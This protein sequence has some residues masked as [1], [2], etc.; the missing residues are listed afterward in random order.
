MSAASRLRCG[1]VVWGIGAAGA[2]CGPVAPG[3][4]ADARA[5]AAVLADETVADP[6]ACAA[7]VDPDLRGDCGVVVAERRMAAGVAPGAV[8]GPLAPG[9]WADEC[10]FRAAEAAM[11]VGDPDAA[12]DL[13]L[14]VRSFRDACAQHLWDPELAGVWVGPDADAALGRGRALH[15]TWA[16]RLGGRTDLDDRFWR[17]WYRLGFAHGVPLPADTA[18]FCAAAP[19]DLA[20][21]CRKAVARAIAEGGGPR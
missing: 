12:A 9:V 20:R 18:A 16:A 14:A 21:P 11:R 17:H 8:C 1:V 4:S 7:L 3:R 2:G 5:Y 15:A 13:C 6:G 19:P 10:R